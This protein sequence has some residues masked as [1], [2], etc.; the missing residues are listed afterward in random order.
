MHTNSGSGFS[1]SLPGGVSGILTNDASIIP[2]YLTVALIVTSMVPYTPPA[3]I[4]SVV[5]S[6]GSLM[7][8]ATGG[9][10]GATVYVLTATNLTVPL[11]D[12]T[13][14]STTTFDG[15]GDL[16]NYSVPGSLNPS[17][18]DQFYLLKQ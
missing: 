4:S 9:T 15:S 8:N 12:W 5:V 13:T 17:L 6:G 1:L 3:T 14:N 16:N 18:P 10:P 7:I 11:A 2:G